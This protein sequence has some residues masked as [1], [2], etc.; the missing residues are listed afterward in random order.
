MANRAHAHARDHV[1]RGGAGPSID[2]PISGPDH[3]RTAM[4]IP[5]LVRSFVVVVSAVSGLSACA[6]LHLASGD[7]S[8]D[9]PATVTATA[10]SNTQISVAWSAVPGA[11][12]YFVFDKKTADA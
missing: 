3:R 4:S 5:S 12:K 11:F 1:R 8:I 7:Q 10:V 6:G 2:L 9:A